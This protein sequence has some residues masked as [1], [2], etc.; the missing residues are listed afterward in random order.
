[1]TSLTRVHR[2]RTSRLAAAFVT[3]VALTACG[4]DGDAGDDAGGV[5]L[6]L[7]IPD[8]NIRQPDVPCSGAQAFR[9]AHP[10]APYTVHDPDGRSVASGELPEGVAVK[11]FTFDMGDERQPT[12]CVMTLEITGVE[13]LDEHTLVIG[14]R[15]PV[16]IRPNPNLDDVPEAVLR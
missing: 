13:S 8:T 9:F 10:G 11:A 5:A 1:M 2:A 15:R 3:A 16:P 7:V 6:R 12:V 4:A 14:D